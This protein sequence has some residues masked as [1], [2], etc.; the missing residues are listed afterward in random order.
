MAIT[1]ISRG[2]QVLQ[3]V[4][5]RKKLNHEAE[6]TLKTRSMLKRGG[7]AMANW[8]DAAAYRI[9]DPNRDVILHKSRSIEITRSEVIMLLNA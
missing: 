5:K 6:I 8:D 1:Q 9:L 3:K 2:K 4:R 7:R